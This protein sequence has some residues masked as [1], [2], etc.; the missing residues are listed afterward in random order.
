MYVYIDKKYVLVCRL[1]IA[2][3][4]ILCSG[5]LYTAVVYG[6][7]NYRGV[8]YSVGHK[9]FYVHLL[10]EIVVLMFFLWWSLFGIRKK[11]T[12]DQ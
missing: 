10:Y 5:E 8:E 7:I 6:Y 4:A 1:L 3:F 11:E 2:F 12:K 9:I